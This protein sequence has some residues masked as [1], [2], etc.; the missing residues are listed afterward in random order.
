MYAVVQGA[1]VCVFRTRHISRVLKFFLHLSHTAS[2]ESGNFTLR[3]CLNP[4]GVKV[5]MFYRGARMEKV[6][7]HKPSNNPVKHAGRLAGTLH[8]TRINLPHE[9]LPEGTS[10]AVNKRAKNKLG[11]IEVTLEKSQKKPKCRLFSIGIDAFSPQTES[12]TSTTPKLRKIFTRPCGTATSSTTNNNGGDHVE[13]L[14][15]PHL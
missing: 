1:V 5:K 4:G 11:L 15:T 6:R 10:F 3:D 7:L 2:R 13:K 12:V 14:P 8:S 9:M